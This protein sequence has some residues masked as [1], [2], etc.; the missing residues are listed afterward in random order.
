[1][2]ENSELFYKISGTGKPLVFLHGFLED[3]SVWNSVYPHFVNLGYKCILVDLPAHGKSRFDGEIC[4]MKYMAE[5]TAEV[6]E[7]NSIE[8]PHVFGHSMGGYVAL[9]MLRIKDCSVT[10]VHSNFW[11]DSETKKSD[12]NRVIEVVKKNKSLFLNESIPNLFAPQNREFRREEIQNLISKA[13]IMPSTEIC[14]AT[15]GLRDRMA[16]YDLMEN[17]NVS[18][19]QG[20]NDSVIPDQALQTEIEK[21]NKKPEVY[22]LENCGHMGF[23]EQN[24]QL[25]NCMEKILIG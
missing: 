12:R 19:I 20:D 4:T 13:M 6:L 14:A 15:A 1:M 2:T 11:A 17:N 16:S 25:I 21:L 18:V 23:I 22:Q 24:G 9:E 5:K 8:N 10:L 3:Q 7:R